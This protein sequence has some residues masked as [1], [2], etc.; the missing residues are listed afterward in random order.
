MRWCTRRGC[1]RTRRS[2]TAFTNFTKT[3]P[4]KEL[5]DAYNHEVIAY[6]GDRD[7]FWSRI[8]ARLDGYDMRPTLQL[9]AA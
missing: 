1:C 8:V 3:E 5:L 6:Q 9:V 2:A 4:Q 7:G